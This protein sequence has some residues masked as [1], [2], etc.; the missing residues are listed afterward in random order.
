MRKLLFMVLFAPAFLC[1]QTTEFGYFSLKEVMDSLPEYSEAQ[2]NYNSL[3]ELCDAEIAQCEET[4]TRNY[5]SFLDGQ[6]TFPEPILR[7]RQKELQEQ[8]DRNVVL[9]DQLNEWLVQAHDSLFNPIV[10]KIDAA[11][12]RVCL[13]NNLAYAIDTDKEAYRFVHPDYGVNITKLIVKEVISPVNIQME[14]NLHR[15][16]DAATYDAEQAD[17]ILCN[18]E[19]SEDVIIKEEGDSVTVTIVEE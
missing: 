3:L 9:R 17:T 14:P 12:E 10:K 19:P 2:N 16:A 1:A 5:V 18:K 6:N 7:R 8:V 11:I 15:I 13:R 4:L